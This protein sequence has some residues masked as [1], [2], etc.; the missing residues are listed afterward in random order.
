VLVID[1]ENESEEEE[2]TEVI[3]VNHHH[4]HSKLNIRETESSSDGNNDDLE[5]HKVTPIE[6][7]SKKSWRVTVCCIKDELR[8]PVSV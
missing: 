1:S 6:V 2:A 8:E 4:K 3:A 7:V 5:F